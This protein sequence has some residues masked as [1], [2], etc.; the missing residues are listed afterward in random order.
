MKEKK[1]DF[2][3]RVSYEPSGLWLVLGLAVVVAYMAM[4]FSPTIPSLASVPP[5]VA[6]EG[7]RAAAAR[8]TVPAEE[9]V[10]VLNSTGTYNLVLSEV[11]PDA[12]LPPAA[13]SK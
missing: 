1:E 8:A 9:W 7:D 11:A 13:T 10:M 2:R 4:I 6:V 12:P 5:P 3:F